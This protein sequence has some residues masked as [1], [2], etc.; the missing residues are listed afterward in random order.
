M[1]HL[2]PTTSTV[3]RLYGSSQFCASPDCREPHIEVDQYTGV[4]I[5]NTQVCHIHARRENGPR[6]NALQS[7]EE[8]RSDMNLLLLCRKHHAIVDERRN[9]KFYTPELLKAWKAAQEGEDDNPLSSDDLE[10]IAQ[11]NVTITAET[12]TLGGEGGAAPGAG[13]GGGAAIG[14]NAQGGRGGDGGR[15]HKDGKLADASA[16]SSWTNVLRNTQDGRPPRLR[17]GRSP[18]HRG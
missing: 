8:N 2:K 11:T 7:S 16:L 4:K 18:C 9:E 5:C 12:V 3:Y 17:R 15:V 10:A 1:E 13:G 6:W 14:A